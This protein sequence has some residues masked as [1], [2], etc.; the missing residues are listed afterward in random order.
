MTTTITDARTRYAGR[1]PT[2]PPPTRAAALAS[3]LRSLVTCWIDVRCDP[4]QCTGIVVLPIKM[5]VR[6]HGGRVTLASVVARLRCSRC[7]ERPV[8]V[9]LVSAPNHGAAFGAPAGSWS[10]VL[11]P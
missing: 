3:P 9:T 8:S 5:L 7:G 10:L 6:Q 11:V 4:A 1:V 2:E